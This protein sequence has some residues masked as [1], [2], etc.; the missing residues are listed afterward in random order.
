M[1]PFLSLFALA[2]LL[3]ACST[4]APEAELT[5]DEQAA[6]DQA[7]AEQRL[8]EYDA[9]MEADEKIFATMQPTD[10][11]GDG[12]KTFADPDFGVS[13]DFPSDWIFDL[14]RYGEDGY[15][16]DLSNETPMDGCTATVA[17]LTFTFPNPKDSTLSFADFVK[18][19]EVYEP[20][21][22]MGVLGG[23]LTPMTLAGK[24]TFKAESAGYET[25]RCHDDAYV[26]E[27][28]ED[29]YLFIG[30]FTGTVGNEATEIEKILD[31]L[32]ID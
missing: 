17:Q 14:S 3:T 27:M 7:E 16:V 22:G 30:L 28:S 9:L 29:E 8:A 25:I 18:S 6:L 32:K 5:F 12:Y 13:F 26:V 23:T 31:S 20:D 15:R 4:T 19:P 24:T 2:F 21:G 10:E 1:K 11:D